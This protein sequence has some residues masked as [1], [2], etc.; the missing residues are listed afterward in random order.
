MLWLC[1]DVNECLSGN[2]GC[3]HICTNTVGNFSCSCTLGFSLDSDLMNCSGKPVSVVISMFMY[4]FQT[5]MSVIP[6]MEAVSIHALTLTVTTLAHVILDISWT[7][8]HSIAL[9][10]TINPEISMIDLLV[11]FQTST[12]A[13][14]TMETVNTPASTLRE[15]LAAPVTLAMNWTA[16]YSTAQVITDKVFVLDFRKLYRRLLLTEW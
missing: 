8:T 2:G 12:S 14:L 9:V 10:S 5:W 15:T 6:T 13:W 16:I 3:E 11:I 1:T 4:Q 7:T